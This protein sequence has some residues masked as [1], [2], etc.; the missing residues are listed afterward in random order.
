MVFGPKT[1][2]LFVIC[3][4]ALRATSASVHT[5]FFAC[6]HSKH[7]L[8]PGHAAGGPWA[9]SELPISSSPF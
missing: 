3:G 7:Y 5:V 1:G 6:H 4:R 2:T 8:G 9:L